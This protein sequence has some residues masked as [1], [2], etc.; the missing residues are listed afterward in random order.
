MSKHADCCLTPD[1]GRSQ[2]CD[3][4]NYCIM[5]V[6]PTLL[7]FD[8]KAHQNPDRKTAQIVIIY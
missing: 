5:E 4:H 6:M 2:R 7:R 1:H 8:R 3:G